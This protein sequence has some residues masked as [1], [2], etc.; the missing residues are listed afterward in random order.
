[1]NSEVAGSILPVF[2]VKEK[3]GFSHVQEPVKL[4]HLKNNDESNTIIS[5]Y[6]NTENVGGKISYWVFHR[7]S[8]HNLEYVSGLVGENVVENKFRRRKLVEVFVTQHF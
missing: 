8:W 7:G 4:N 5:S 1:M 3:K 6:S 2:L